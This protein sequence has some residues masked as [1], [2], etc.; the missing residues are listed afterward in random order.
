MFK[1]ISLNFSGKG[2]LVEGVFYCWDVRKSIS[3][4]LP[5]HIFILLTFQSLQM[6]GALPYKQAMQNMHYASII[7]NAHF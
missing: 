5:D 6:S 4:C 7:L 1:S 3:L 2:T